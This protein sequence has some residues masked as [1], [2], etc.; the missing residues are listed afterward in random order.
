MFKNNVSWK[1]TIS[2]W[3]RNRW[4]PCDHHD[5]K[6]DTKQLRQTTTRCWDSYQC[7]TN[8]KRWDST[9]QWLSTRP[10]CIDSRLIGKLSFHALWECFRWNCARNCGGRILFDASPWEDR[11]SMNWGTFTQ[12]WA[13]L[14]VTKPAAD[15]ARSKWAVWKCW[16]SGTRRRWGYRTSWGSGGSL[17]RPR[18]GGV[19][20]LNP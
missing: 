7:Q 5:S 15:L 4:C 11:C 16:C 8:W 18:A 20:L 12:Q 13:N 3:K 2:F 6:T 10:V 1:H 9:I 14:L 19:L 17:L